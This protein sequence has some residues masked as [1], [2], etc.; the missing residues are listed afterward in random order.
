MFSKLLDK[1]SSNKKNILW[2]IGWFLL[3]FVLSD[4]VFAADTTLDK[5]KTTASSAMSWIWATLTLFL[6]LLTYLTTV[7]LSPEWINGSLFWL[8]SYFKSIWIL[9]SNVVYL[10][11]AFIIIWIAFMNIIWKWQEK[12]A[13]KQALPKFIVGIL[14][15][16]FS[17]F[18]VQFILSMSAVLTISALNI[19]F[20]SFPQYKTV[21]DKTTIPNNCTLNLKSIWSSDTETSTTSTTATKT[22]EDSFFS[23][24]D[25]KVKWNSSTISEILNSWKASDSIFGII[26][27]YTYWVLWLENIAKLNEIDLTN[28]QTMWDLVVKLL[29][30]V[31]FV[32]VYAILLV[33]LWMVLMV[34]GIYIWI[35]MMISP[36]FWLMYFF[37]KTSGWGEFF[38]KFNVKQFIS[39]AMVPVYSMLALSF[40]LLFLFVIW[41]W[42]TDKKSDVLQGVQIQEGESTDS[43]KIVIW[44]D[45][46]W[47]WGFSL[48]VVWSPANEQN[49]TW[50]IKNVGNNTLW[51][52]WTLIMKIFG[53]VVL[54]WAVMA[55]LRSNDM[56]KAIIEPLHAFGWQVWWLITKAPQYAPI[57]G[58]QSMTSMSQI[59]SSASSYF[60]TK[61]RERW[62][63]FMKKHELFWQNW[64]IDLSNKSI[65]A[66]QRLQKSNLND[67]SVWDD[68]KKAYDEWNDIQSLANNK[69]YVELLQ[70]MLKKWWNEEAAKN[71][72]FWD[73]DSIAKWHIILDWIADTKYNSQSGGWLI[74][75]TDST[76]SKNTANDL[77][78]LKRENQKNQDILTTENQTINLNINWVWTP[79]NIPQSITSPTIKSDIEKAITNVWAI[80]NVTKV[81]FISKIK[82]ELKIKGISDDDSEKIANEVASKITNFKTSY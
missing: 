23:C 22:N 37:D 54:W 28:I 57:F 18:L 11:F 82:S 20:E 34:R 59:G 6:S 50:F 44:W 5:A 40:W 8:N 49:I 35:Y 64:S 38:D 27:T 60:E 67:S 77:D 30:D 1:I 10:I 47:K 55:A 69:N 56:T 46:N 74:K 51:V 79:V 13:L 75:W 33:A 9:V 7:F 36:L 45:S 48:S 32:L 80:S 81:D 12:Y 2:I 41:N 61:A 42:M 52:V 19:P 17:W 21:M 4:S 26:S 65:N 15:V 29:F 73:R 43:S 62:T 76:W 53:I 39:L 72:K 31:L 68:Y 24:K 3:F 70:E 63:D 14:I 25:K 16:P 58:G 66:L 71:I 78:K